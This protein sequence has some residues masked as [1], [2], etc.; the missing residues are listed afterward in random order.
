MQFFVSRQFYYY[1]QINAV[2]IAFPSIDYSGPDMLCEKYAGEGELYDDPRDAVN[3]AIEIKEMWE[4]DSGEVVVITAGSFDGFEGEESTVE[5]L[6]T[7][8]EKQYDSMEKCAVCGEILGENWYTNQDSEFSEDKF[9]S[10]V[11]A[12]KAFFDNLDLC[13][14][15]EKELARK[16]MNYISDFNFICNDCVE[17]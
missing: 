9:C 15:C 7:W 10:E 14:V 13:S 12:D 5:E 2:E 4:K 11:H 3:A 6:R 16:E 17:A 8:A 1:Q